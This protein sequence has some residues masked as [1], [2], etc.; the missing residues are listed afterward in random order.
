MKIDLPGADLRYAERAFDPVQADALFSALRGEIEWEQHRLRLFGREVTAPRLSAWIGDADASYRY[1]G[2]RFEPRAWTPAVACLRDDLNARLGVR[3]NSVLANL[4]RDGCDSMG[5]H[6]DDEPELGV[7]PLIASLSFGAPRR[8]RLRARSKRRAA[9]SIELAHGSLL[10]MAG[11]TQR[12]YQ[13]ALP[14]TK[15]R[16]GERINLTFR[17]IE[18]LIANRHGASLCDI[19]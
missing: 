16:I 2:T 8:L 19:S 3:F 5:W 14:K 15:T 10:L 1:S 13:H 12:L 6:A 11:A 4:Y 18:P 17:R 9:V 7:Q